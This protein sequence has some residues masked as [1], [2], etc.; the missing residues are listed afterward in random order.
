MQNFFR[1]LVISMNTIMV[2]GFYFWAVNWVVKKLR[3]PFNE[4]ML[5]SG[6]VFN[7]VMVAPIRVNT[8]TLHFMNPIYESGFLFCS[9]IRS[10]ALYL[11]FSRSSVM[12]TY[13][14]GEPLVECDYHFSLEL[15]KGVWFILLQ[16]W[17]SGS[18]NAPYGEVVFAG[19]DCGMIFCSPCDAASHTSL[20]FRRV[21]CKFHSIQS[22][23]SVRA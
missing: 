8:K 7:Q 4:S 3:S 10:C 23:M 12:V 13:G 14:V 16:L 18:K 2:L 9:K 19:V 15:G 11:P 5:S 21:H 1:L 17:L 22:I 20:A 6:R